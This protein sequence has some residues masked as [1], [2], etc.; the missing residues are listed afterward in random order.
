[1]TR[2]LILF[3]IISFDFFLNAQNENINLLPDENFPLWLKTE[4]SRTNQTSGIAFIKT[5]CDKKYFLL[6]DDIGFIHLLTLESDSIYSIDSISFTNNTDE[7]LAA[8]PKKDFEEI[9]YDQSTGSVYLSIEGNGE[10]FNDYVGIYK[11]IFKDNDVLSKQVISIEKMNFKP[12]DLFYKYTN[13]NTG[14]EGFALN[15]NYFYLG[16]EGFVNNYQFADST[17]IFIANKSHLN[18]VKTISTKNLGIH[19]ICGLFSDADYSLW[20]IDRNSRMIFHILFDS[21]FNINSFLKFD[22]T[23]SIPGYHSLNYLPSYESITMDDDDN[24]YIVDDPWKEVFVPEEEILDQLDNETI[25]NFK[26]YIPIIFK[27]KKTQP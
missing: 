14:Y 19:T 27:Y 23:T 7:Y 6:A 10:D 17:L 13:W 21:E 15:D 5:E 9:V 2:V 1:M 4:Q 18:I 16:L 3:F 26:G 25:N 11:L 8:F 20:G 12:A 24:I 22:G